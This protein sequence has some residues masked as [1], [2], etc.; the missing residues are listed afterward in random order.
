MDDV[1]EHIASTKHLDR[2]E[3]GDPSSSTC[4]LAGQEWIPVEIN[5]MPMVLDCHVVY[6]ATMFGSGRVLYDHSLG[7]VVAP[8]I[9]GGV[10]LLPRHSYSVCAF[11]LPSE[12][13]PL[14]YKEARD[15]SCVL[16]QSVLSRPR[17]REMKPSNPLSLSRQCLSRFNDGVAEEKKMF[18]R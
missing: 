2:V 15:Y 1:F 17:R 11:V 14:P 16:R 10:R 8:D 18:E 4:G 5:G 12:E 6:P 13:R 9:C 7:A 3:A